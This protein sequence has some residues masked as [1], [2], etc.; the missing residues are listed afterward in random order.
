MEV[1]SDRGYLLL[2]AFHIFS[3][4]NKALQPRPSVLKSQTSVLSNDDSLCRES[5]CVPNAK[6]RLCNAE[7]VVSNNQQQPES[8]LNKVKL[9][10]KCD[11]EES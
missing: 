8:A 4:Q 9:K 5:F 10:L 6:P 2:H 11:H 1:T 7:T 3:G